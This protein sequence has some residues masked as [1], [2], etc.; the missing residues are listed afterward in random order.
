MNL[1]DLVDIVKFTTPF[2]EPPFDQNNRPVRLAFAGQQGRLFQD[3]L[4][5]HRID[6]TEAVCQGTTAHITCLT[7]RADLPLEELLGLPMEAQLVTDRG[8]LRRFCTIVT[9]VVQGQSDGSLTT[10]QLTGRDA[11]AVLDWRCSN[12]IFLN[13]S[14]LEVVR[15]VL[16]GV[17][18]RF[19]ALA[20]A[21]D[22]LLPGI[23]EARYPQ[24]AFTFQCHE[25]DA[26]FIRRLLRRNGI[27]W[28]F[29]PGQ[30]DDYPM[31]EL[32]LFD[33][34][35]KLP[36][37][38][39]GAVRYQRRDGT[40]ERDSINLLAPART[41]VGGAVVRSSYDHD[42]ARVD[43]ENGISGVDQGTSGNR[44]AAALVDARIEL[45]HAGDSWDHHE[46]LTRLDMRRI[47]A[48]ASC[49]HG[50]GGVRDQAVGEWN[51]I[52][53]HP[54]ID[55]LPAH[56][57]GFVT[58]RM[59]HECENNFAKE[60]NERAQALLASSETSI[61]GWVGRSQGGKDGEQRY[62]NRFTA[63]RRDSAIVPAW[64]PETDLPR[65]PLM[66]AVVLGAEGEPV[67]CDELGR[68]KVRILGLDPL[69][70]E[71]AQTHDTTAW[72][73]VDYMWAGNGFGIIFPLR[74]GME[75]SLGW[76]QGDVDRPV[77][78]GCRYNA[79]NIPPRFDHL[80]S[81]PNNGA[82]NGVV[83]QELNGQQQ[84]Q[85]RFNDTHGKI[86]TQLGTD[87][88]ATQIN[89][90][91][92]STPM[93]EGKTEPRG[94]GFEG[95]TDSSLALRAAMAM[96]LSTYARPN[97]TGHQLSCEELAGHLSAALAQATAQG[98]SA[99]DNQADGTDTA[100][101]QQLR[102]H[103][104]HWQNGSNTAPNAAGGGQPIIGLSAAAGIVAATPESATLSAGKSLDLVAAQHIQ[105]SA[106]KR[107]AVRAAESISLFAHRLGAKIVAA[108]GAL[109]L[110]ALKGPI[111][112]GASERVHIYSSGGQI[113]AEAPD[114]IV[115]RTR[116]AEVTLQDGKITFN[117]TGEFAAKASNFTFDGPG[118]VAGPSNVLAAKDVQYDQRI[119]LRHMGTDEPMPHQRYRVTTEEGQ[120]FDGK[121]DEHGLTQRFPL[122]IAFG[123]YIIEP[124]YD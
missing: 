90:G 6:I 17:R 40:E 76:E 16:D 47:D 54:Q 86:S 73:R 15:I 85:L 35:S 103:V 79:R 80:G 61:R 114:G 50:I 67:Q 89:M 88:A 66:T 94:E 58:L 18:Q 48:R 93:N 91:C 43:V 68:V 44:L 108:M 41:L 119:V 9:D 26:Q 24:R 121:T 113:I 71:S 1:A 57:R 10:L 123:R 4:L 78:T 115:W 45:P 59:Q 3:L 81:L 98:Q 116:G 83:T 11:F 118:S 20:Q 97:A 21:F 60:L 53:G 122:S 77:I 28:F 37:N 32:V 14:P 112:I 36:E 99:S 102:D 46:R 55:T 100:A 39:A 31:Q 106:G 56:E 124:L 51:R 101:Q 23:D 104:D 38:A 29:R 70:D 22:Y 49:L 62:T 30:K 19:P 72:V 110:L 84:Q 2:A 7:P 120:S 107:Y 75:V 5:P 117:A 34:A 96:L 8:E 33:D 63:V 12:R 27:S 64:N 95:R 42:A 111:E 105:L 52:D 109:K 82:L 65:M 13:K 92:L 25:S 87:H 74:A 69:D